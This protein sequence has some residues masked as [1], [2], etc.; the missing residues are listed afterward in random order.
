MK[1]EM[2]F[3]QLTLF[4]IYFSVPSVAKNNSVNQ[5]KS[6]SK[7]SLRPLRSLRLI[8]QSKPQ[9]QKCLPACS[10]FMLAGGR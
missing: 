7:K 8:F 2:P 1:R 10:E 3:N 4:T 9:Q 6:V 5:C